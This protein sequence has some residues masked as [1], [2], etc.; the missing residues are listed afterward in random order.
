MGV[1]ERGGALFSGGA[2]AACS[3]CP[4]TRRCLVKP[5]RR[6]VWL[7]AVWTVCAMAMVAPARGADNGKTLFEWTRLPDIPTQVLPDSLSG[8]EDAYIGGS[9][10][11]MIVAGGLRRAGSDGG[12]GKP[13][14]VSFNC[15]RKTIGP[16]LHV[17]DYWP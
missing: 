16:I 4:V 17:N 11:A 5:A 6:R 7:V 3:C 10:E 12:P 15:F 8:I 9:D 1:C 2:P 14:N 13:M